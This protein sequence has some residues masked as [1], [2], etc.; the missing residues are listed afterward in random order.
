MINLVLSYLSQVQ[1]EGIVK[2]ERGR[3]KLSSV[4]KALDAFWPGRDTEACKLRGWVGTQSV[5]LRVPGV[6]RLG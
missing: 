2:K 5:A 6:F 1:S 4:G 3:R